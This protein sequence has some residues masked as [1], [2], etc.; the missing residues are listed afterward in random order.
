[1]SRG[2]EQVMW[3][4]NQEAGDPAEIVMLHR[5]VMIALPEGGK[6]GQL[7]GYNERREL[8][9]VDPPTVDPLEGSSG[10]IG[11]EK[12]PPLDHSHLPDLS[13]HYQSVDERDAPGGYAGLD[14]NGKLSPYAL[15]S[16]ARGMQGERGTQGVR[17][18]KGEK[19]ERGEKGNTG[20]Q[21]PA[22][23]EGPEGRAGVAGPR[24]AAPDLSA[25]V[26][27]LSSPP[28]LSLSSETLARDL[29]YLLAELEL[30]RLT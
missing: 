23:R 5:P 16:I 11:K 24:A 8:V 6:P 29:A 20:L 19:G 21:G 18:E 14:A 10:L 12:I 1:M 26:R 22:G 30:I 15:P 2:P 7:L 27:R 28:T 25:Y 17:G 9:W 13:G 4:H 3:P